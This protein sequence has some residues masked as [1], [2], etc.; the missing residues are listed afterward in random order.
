VKF[1][2]EILMA[3]KNNNVNKIPNYDPSHFEH[4]KK[5]LKSFVRE[6]NY[7]TEMKVSLDDLLKAD[8]RGRWWIVGSAFTGH[9][10]GVKGDTGKDEVRKETKE[11]FS[12]KLLDLA[13]KMRMNTDVRKNIFCIVMSAEDYLDAFE[14]LVKLGTKNQNERE[15]IFVLVDCCVQE[16]NFNPY[17]P[18]LISKLATFDRKYRL[19]AQFTI[20]DKLKQIDDL[21]SVQVK[22]LGQLTCHLIKE[23]SQ[24]LSVLKVIQFS[25]MNKRN[26]AYLREVLLGILMQKNAEQLVEAFQAVAES[27]KLHV[28]REGLRLFMQHFLI[29]QSSKLAESLDKELMKKRI[30]LSET[31]LLAAGSSLKL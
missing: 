22:N 7:V 16:K 31:A 6:G 17:Y 29:K 26:V 2:L 27:P 23:K 30:R 11:K 8:E 18:K 25:E 14:K 9:L 19:A 21:K 1:M 13:R 20:W 4:L 3:I 28:F 5:T 10:Q 12:S 15:V 24:P